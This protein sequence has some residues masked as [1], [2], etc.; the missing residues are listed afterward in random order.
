MSIETTAKVD[1]KMEKVSD[2][3]L[4]LR[5]MNANIAEFRQR[6]LITTRFESAVNRIV[7]VQKPEMKNNTMFAIELRESVPYYVEK[8]DN[9]IMIHFEASTIPPKPL[10]QANMPPWQKVFDETSLEAMKAPT[11]TEATGAPAGETVTLTETDIDTG[12]FEGS[13]PLSETNAPGVLLIAE[14]DTITATYIDADDGE[15]GTN[16][17]VTAAALVDCTA[18]IISNVQVTDVGPRDAYVTFETDEPTLGSVRYGTSC[19]ALSESAAEGGYNTLH[20]VHL[21]GLGSRSR[22]LH[23]RTQWSEAPG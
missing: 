22:C 13:I 11:M 19:D 15:G 4:E 17:V 7:P 14:T 16:I 18:P 2:K 1:Y 10:E 8:I 6:P 21:T 3:L 20:S 9:L 23:V 5:L 12:L